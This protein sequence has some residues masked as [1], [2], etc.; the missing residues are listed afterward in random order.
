[1]SQIMS[2]NAL[3]TFFLFFSVAHGIRI[4]VKIQWK[5][6]EPGEVE[7]VNRLEIFSGSTGISA[8]EK[9]WLTMTQPIGFTE[10]PVYMWH[11]DQDPHS[12]PP[13]DLGAK[14]AFQDNEKQFK[15]SRYKSIPYKIRHFPL[16]PSPT[17]RIPPIMP[18][19]LVNFEQHQG[20]SP[21]IAGTISPLEK[22]DSEAVESGDTDGEGNPI[23]KDDETGIA[24]ETPPLSKPKIADDGG[25]LIGFPNK[26]QP[27]DITAFKRK[28]SV[29][30]NHYN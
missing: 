15:K 24:Y 13:G 20:P 27:L 30:L 14:L 5:P 16:P 19:A 12:Y 1:M 21:P 29:F 7:K 23:K 26:R 9:A 6:D 25:A 2:T 10:P 18:F 28:D 22:K 4:G 8:A 11:P 3:Y 17:T